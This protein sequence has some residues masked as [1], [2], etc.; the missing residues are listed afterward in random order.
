LAK[1]LTT[2]ETLEQKID[3][4]SQNSRTFANSETILPSQFLTTP[5]QEATGFHKLLGWPE[6]QQLLQCDLSHMSY[7]DG[8]DRTTEQW[9]S[10]LADT[11]GEPLATDDRVDFSNILDE[12]TGTGAK[13]FVASREHLEMLC[14]VYFQTF[15]SIYP[16]LDAYKFKTETLPRVI[17][18][19]FDENDSQSALALAVLALGALAYEGSTGDPLV[20]EE[21][22]PS[23]GVRGGSDTRPPGIAF[24]NEA[25]I[26]MGLMLHKWDLVILQ[27]VILIA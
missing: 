1:I 4:V 13:Q 9:L 17:D 5:P 22:R 23:L 2:L 12:S 11:F 18:N 8:G 25:K 10:E 20:D 16:I 21:G 26:R 19:S 24:L 7:W 14:S 15:H 3:R 27:C 6:V